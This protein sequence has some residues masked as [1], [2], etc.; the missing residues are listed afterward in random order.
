VVLV[1]LA[2]NERARKNKQEGRRVGIGMRS[3][4]LAIVLFAVRVSSLDAQAPAD[5]VLSALAKHQIV[6]LG[7]IHPLAEPKLIVSEVITRQTDQSRIDLLA[8]EVGADQQEW[9]DRYFATVPED[10]TILLEHPRTLRVHW[11]ASSE[12][13]G[14]YR[15]VYRWNSSGAGWQVHVLAADLRGWPVAPL[16]QGMAVGAFVNRDDWMAAAFRKSLLPHPDWH[17]LI[18]M[19][20]YHGLRTIGGDVKVGDAHDG[21]DNWFAGHLV[22]SGLQVYSILTDAR[23][24]DGRAATRVFD[25]LAPRYPGLNV[26]IPLDSTTDAIREPLYD[27]EQEGYHLEFRPS[28]FAFRSAVDAMV[29]LN[30]TTRITLIGEK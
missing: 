26:A 9:I 29:V 16:T 24:D 17:V 18:F 4:F 12:Y 28:R 30:R 1:E 25:L 21:F 8:L 19:G 10:T 6:F 27:I 5:F 20:G 15:A 7:D 22:A 14:I 11:G 13:L 2:G 3:T 23:Q